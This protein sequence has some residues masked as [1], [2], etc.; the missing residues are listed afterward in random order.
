MTDTFKRVIQLYRVRG[1]TGTVS[2]SGLFGIYGEKL[3]K[4]VTQ[5]QV[6]TPTVERVL[7]IMSGTARDQGLEDSVRL[8]TEDTKTAKL[9]RTLIRRMENRAGEWATG[10]MASIDPEIGSEGTIGFTVPVISKSPMPLSPSKT[11]LVASHGTPIFSFIDIGWTVTISLTINSKRLLFWQGI[12]RE[13]E[14]TGG[15]D[16]A[17]AA[18]AAAS[19]EGAFDY[20]KAVSSG[21]ATM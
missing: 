21:S 2:V 15:G 5:D 6:Q 9:I 8:D 17:A 11:L 4:Y 10:E 20:D 13:I 3:S 12:R 7:S 1:Y 19:S 16:A 14:V 18:A